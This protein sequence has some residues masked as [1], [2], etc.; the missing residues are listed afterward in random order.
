MNSTEIQWVVLSS[1]GSTVPSLSLS[2]GGFLLGSHKNMP[3]GGKAMANYL[4]Q[5]VC[6]WCVLDKDSV[7][8]GPKRCSWVS[9]VRKIHNLL[10]ASRTRDEY[11]PDD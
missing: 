7:N 3:V 2:L 6:A 11:W 8:K 9:D 4:F 1:Q 5:S 10:F